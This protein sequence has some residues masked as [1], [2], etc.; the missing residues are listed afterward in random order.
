MDNKELY[1][2]FY[3][4]LTYF[5]E[6][7]ADVLSGQQYQILLCGVAQTLFIIFIAAIVSAMFGAFGYLLGTKRGGKRG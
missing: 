3:D 2:G 4:F 6:P 7:F 5:L 1:S